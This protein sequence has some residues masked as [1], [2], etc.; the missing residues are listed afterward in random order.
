MD[1]QTRTKISHNEKNSRA[2]DLHYFEEK[3]MVSPVKKLM[4]SYFE[5]NIFKYLLRSIKVNIGNKRILEV[6]CGAGYGIIQINKNF[7][8]LEYYAFDSSRKMV[9]LSIAKAK[10]HE[11]PV[12]IFWGD[13][14]EINLEPNKFDVVFVFTVLH[15]VEGWQ[16]ALKEINRVL[17]PKGLLLINEINIRS[18]NWFERY[19][20]VYHPK[21]AR[22]TWSMFQQGLSKANFH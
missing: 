16:E 10:K 6:G 19:L 8:P 12:N 15:H 5:I 21:E 18:L 9:S 11:I 3:L 13:V 4:L 1:S 20:K 2:F 14:R 17:K 22:F 7:A